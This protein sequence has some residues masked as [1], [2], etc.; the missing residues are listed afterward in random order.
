MLGS[1]RQ[2]CVCKYVGFMLA[3]TTT[4]LRYMDNV[5]N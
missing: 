2:G 4:E 3:Y 1:I 5:K